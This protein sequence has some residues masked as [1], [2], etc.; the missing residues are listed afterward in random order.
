M[1]GCPSEFRALMANG[2]LIS[3]VAAKVGMSDYEDTLRGYL[4]DV[5]VYSAPTDKIPQAKRL[6]RCAQN[7]DLSLDD[8]MYGRT[9][10]KNA[11]GVCT[12]SS[13]QAIFTR[14]TLKLTSIRNKIKAKQ[15]L[16]TDEEKLHKCNWH[17]GISDDQSLDH[18]RHR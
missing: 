9:Y 12:Q 2:S 16:T 4:G 3:K 17:A 18:A 11:A 6:A 5:M 13:G 14:V 1:E 7:D 10:T 15:V 8:M